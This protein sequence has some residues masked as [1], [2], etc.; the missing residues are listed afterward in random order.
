MTCNLENYS[1]NIYICFNVNVIHVEI[2]TLPAS[3]YHESIEEPLA[4]FYRNH[5]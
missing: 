3:T 1:I 4:Y 2:V 5:T